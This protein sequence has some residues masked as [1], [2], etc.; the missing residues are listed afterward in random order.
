MKIYYYTK[1]KKYK[2]KDTD[3]Y[4]KKSVYDYTKKDNIAVYRTKEGKPYVDDVFVSVTH[5][6]YF[7]VIC[8]SDSEVGIDAEKKNRKVMFKS[9]IIKKYFSKKEKEYTLNSDIGFLEVWV[10]KEAYLKFLGTGLKDIKNADTFNLNG[11]FTKIDH[12]DL[13]I[14]IYTE[15]N[16]SL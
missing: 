8:V 1:E 2:S 3:E 16:S 10:K 13:I 12:K 9:R 6:D 5:T 7:L 14:Y 15:E 11:K 4:I